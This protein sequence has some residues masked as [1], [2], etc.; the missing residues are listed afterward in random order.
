[1]ADQKAGRTGVVD[2]QIDRTEL[3]A[4]AGERAGHLIGY[5]NVGGNAKDLRTA[6]SKLFG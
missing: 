5:P 2:Q 1:M 6:Q 4:N 3:V